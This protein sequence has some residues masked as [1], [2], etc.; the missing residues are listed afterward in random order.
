M[1]SIQSKLTGVD[2]EN[3]TS[4]PKFNKLVTET[5]ETWKVYKVN[6]QELTARMLQVYPNSIN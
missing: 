3:V 5:D 1:E 4:I 6:S 2:G